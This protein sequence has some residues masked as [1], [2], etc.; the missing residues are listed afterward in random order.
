MSANLIAKSLYIYICIN[1]CMRES[2]GYNTLYE[3][4]KLF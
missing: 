2:A 4:G 3:K 1:K